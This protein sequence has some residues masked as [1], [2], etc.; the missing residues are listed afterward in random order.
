MMEPC[1]RAWTIPK[2]SAAPVPAPSSP[3]KARTG[4]RPIASI[5]TAPSDRAARYGRRNRAMKL[6]A[7]F[8]FLSG[9]V[10]LAAPALAAWP[11]HPVRVV[12][13]YP[14]GGPV[15]LVARLISERLA[16]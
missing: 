15:D 14:P 5:S 1:R 16:A 13:P 2:C 4:M 6:R 7:F 8:V 3:P 11:D 12:V 9:L 10:G